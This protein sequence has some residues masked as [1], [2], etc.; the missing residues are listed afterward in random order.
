VAEA[1]LGREDRLASVTELETRKTAFNTVRARRVGQRVDLDVEGATF[2]TWHPEH[3]MTG[4]SWDAL[5][6]AALLA[7]EPPRSILLLGLGGGT[8]TR[9]LRSFLPHTRLVGVEIDAAVIDLANKYMELGTQVV[10]SH[11][12]DAY[13]F[14]ARSNE[15][16]DAILDDLFLCGPDDVV[17]SRVPHG[18]TLALL[19]ARLTPGGVLVANLI[20]DTGEHK[21]VRAATRKAFLDAFPSVRVVTPPRGLN[22]VLVAGERTLPRSALDGYADRLTDKSDRLRLREIRVR[23]LRRAEEP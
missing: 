14:L 10:E 3:V 4:Y 9:Q 22:E 20:T 5:S 18:D 16:F 7:P 13:A 21:N 6:V 15:K 17:R 2:A 8:S 11:I 19:R 23:L 12:E 1:G